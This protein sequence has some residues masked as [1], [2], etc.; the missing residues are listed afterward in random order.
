MRLF[1]VL[2]FISGLAACDFSSLIG[3]GSSSPAPAPK[4]PGTAHAM[5]YV[6]PE[7]GKNYCKDSD[8]W[9]DDDSHCHT[10]AGQ[11]YAK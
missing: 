9:C 7:T 3:G 11:C 2:G 6:N 10:T 4:K 8:V 5:P 1:I